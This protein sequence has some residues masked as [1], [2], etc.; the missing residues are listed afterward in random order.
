MQQRKYYQGTEKPV[1]GDHFGNDTLVVILE[2][3]NGP[4]LQQQSGLKPLYVQVM[5]VTSAAFIQADQTVLVQI[6]L[7]KP[8]P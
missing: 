1:R 4:S 5:T 2:L 7:D 8:W 6:S 3:R